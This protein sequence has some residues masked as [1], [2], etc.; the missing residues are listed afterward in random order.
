MNCTSL[1]INDMADLTGFFL[2]NC[3][4]EPA[5]NIAQLCKCFKKKKSKS[6]TEESQK[7]P[8]DSQAMMSLASES[9]TKDTGNLP[10][11]QWLNCYSCTHCAV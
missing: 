9:S 4:H 5:T 2:F 1:K 7:A 3:Y 8:S 10:F 11:N 6:N